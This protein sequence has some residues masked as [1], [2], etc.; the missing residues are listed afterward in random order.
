MTCRSTISNKTWYTYCS[1]L[2]ELW[3]ASRKRCEQILKE[4]QRSKSLIKETREKRSTQSNVMLK[5]WNRK[6]EVS[7]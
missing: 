1:R 2:E 4:S 7:V 6:L 3:K 5:D